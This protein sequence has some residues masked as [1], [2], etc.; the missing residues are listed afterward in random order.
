MSGVF[1][2]LRHKF[3]YYLIFLLLMSELK[4]PGRL[5]VVRHGYSILNE[6]HDIANLLLDGREPLEMVHGMRD[7]DVPLTPK[8]ERQ[9]EQT[10]EF[11]ATQ[12]NFDAA[13]SSP[14]KRCVET[15]RHIMGKLGHN[16]RLYTDNRLRE[17][18]AGWMYGMTSKAVKERF[19][20]EAERR[21]RDGRYWYRPPGGENFPDVEQRI[22]QFLDKLHRDHAGQQVLVV[23]HAV[24]YVWFRALFEHLSE[25][26]FLNVDEKNPVPNCGVAIYDI[27]TSENPEGR[28]RL[29]RYNHVAYKN[30][31]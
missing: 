20:D 1:L 31:E 15:T 13:L 17:R 25:S 18:E 12:G 6:A 23:T 27:N 22:H 28:M 3:I 30:I 21:K 4:W 16:P 11:L 19:P 14:Y 9:A 26:E 29:S 7:M 2:V 8:G 5:V 10:G 24:P